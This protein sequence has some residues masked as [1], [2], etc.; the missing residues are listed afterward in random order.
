MRI[1]VL[2][3]PGQLG[4]DLLPRLTGEVIPLSRADI[5]LTRRE[6]IRPKLEEI[7]PAVVVNCAAYNFVDKAET[8]PMAALAANAFGVRH[9]A[10]ACRIIGAK[11]VHV[12]TDYVFGQDTTRRTPLSGNRSTRAGERLRGE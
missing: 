4:R 9:L 10:L 12:S 3:A 2:G 5:D 8:E 11:L 6:M 1:A 7:R